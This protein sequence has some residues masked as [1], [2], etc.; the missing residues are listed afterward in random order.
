MPPRIE[1]HAAHVAADSQNQEREAD[2]KRDNTARQFLLF[3]RIGIRAELLLADLEISAT[4]VIGTQPFIEF[5]A[6][7]LVQEEQ[8]VL[9]LGPLLLPVLANDLG[10]LLLNLQK[11]PHFQRAKKLAVSI[12]TKT[13]SE[14]PVLLKCLTTE[15]VSSF[16]LK[17]RPTRQCCSSEGHASAEDAQ[18]RWH[19]LNSITEIA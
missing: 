7:R 14:L 8:G 9:G 13:S 4:S 5:E 19:Y 12:T 15:N 6:W 16:K 18:A 10:R 17:Q 1:K 3:L 11:G 2:D